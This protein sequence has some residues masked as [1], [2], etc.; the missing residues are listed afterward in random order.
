MTRAWHEEGEVY[1][2]PTGL[3]SK[4]GMRIAAD[5]FDNP[6]PH[7]SLIWLGRIHDS[8]WILAPSLWKRIHSEDGTAEGFGLSFNHRRKPNA[9]N[10]GKLLPL[11]NGVRVSHHSLCYNRRRREEEEEKKKISLK[12]NGFVFVSM[13]AF[14]A[15]RTRAE[16]SILE[17]VK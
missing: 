14:A 1:R 17:H 16:R 6:L 4:K 10:R 5:K 11:I 2:H 7:C 13:C 3:G 12:K 15:L 8:C 9:F